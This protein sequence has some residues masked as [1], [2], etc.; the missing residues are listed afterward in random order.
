LTNTRHDHS[1]FDGVRVVVQL[2]E[3]LPDVVFP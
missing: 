1:M 3:P 2:A